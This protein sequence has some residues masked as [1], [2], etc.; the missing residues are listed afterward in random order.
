M[1]NRSH[2][3]ALI[4]FALAGLIISTLAGCANSEAP[5]SWYASD[6]FERAQVAPGSSE[7]THENYRDH[8]VM[9]TLDPGNT[10]SELSWE[11]LYAN[12]PKSPM[13]QKKFAGLE[14]DP[15]AFKQALDSYFIAFMNSLAQPQTHKT[16]LE[17]SKAHGIEP[18]TLVA[19]LA[20]EHVFNV[21]GLD[22]VQDYIGRAPAWATLWAKGFNT[23]K[24]GIG[25]PLADILKRSEF[26][27]CNSARNEADKWDCFDDVWRAKFSGKTDPS[28]GF[29]W[30]T[31]TLRQVFFDPRVSG[32]TYGLGQLDPQ[33]ALMVA[34]RVRDN[35]RLPMI[36]INDP[37]NL[38]ESIINPN[39]GL[40]FVAANVRL[41]MDRY[42]SIANFDISKNPGISATLYNLGQEDNKAAKLYAENVKLM[43]AGQKPRYPRENYYGWYVNNKLDDIRRYIQTGRY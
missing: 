22:K 34:D 23:Q 15:V 28:D 6:L 5:S 43:S 41:A 8:K 21:N 37:Q 25:T 9:I 39:T 35:S 24:F 20:G 32:R 3:S 26:A 33:R 36:S 42:A 30:P 14:S 19:V 10:N 2:P 31:G 40:H 13:K 1:S 12:V 17:A 38:Y 4:I 11:T 18:V 7:I 29:K 27:N 16:I